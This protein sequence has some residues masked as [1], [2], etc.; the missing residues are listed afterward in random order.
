MRTDN[1]RVPLTLVVP[2]GTIHQE[3]YTSSNGPVIDVMWKGTISYP[4][5]AQF[6]FDIP[7]LY[8][9]PFLQPY[10]GQSKPFPLLVSEGIFCGMTLDGAMNVYTQEWHTTVSVDDE[11]LTET[12]QVQSEQGWIETVL[13]PILH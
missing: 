9:L 4:P 1:L 11:R 6:K 13:S 10:T 3:A 12:G 7:T 8:Q 5:N 2:D